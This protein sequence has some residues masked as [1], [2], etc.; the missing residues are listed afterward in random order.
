MVGAEGGGGGVGELEWGGAGGEVIVT[1]NRASRCSWAVR[2]GA[3][4]DGRRDGRR[5]RISDEWS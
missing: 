2:R 5:C 3:V 1:T 4:E